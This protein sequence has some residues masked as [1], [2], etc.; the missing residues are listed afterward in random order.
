MRSVRIGWRA[1]AASALLAST[2]AADLPTALPHTLHVGSPQ[3][4]A[5]ARDVDA[6]RSRRAAE[7][8]APDRARV[9]WHRQLPGGISCNVLVDAEGRA[10][11]AG[12][13]RVSQL[14]RDGS[15]QFSLT[16]DFSAAAAA[17]L[18]ADG[19]RVLLTREGRLVGWSPAGT[20]AFDVALDAAAPAAS[21]SLLPL[22]DGGL[23][24][25]LG[26]WLFELDAT[27][28][29]RQFTSLP[30]ALQHTLRLEQHSVAVD[31]RG[32]VYTW[33]GREAPRRIGAFSGP[34]AA[35][36]ADGSALVGVAGR[37][38]ERLDARGD[39]RELARFDAGVAP[40]LALPA[41]GQPIAMQLDGVWSALPGGAPPSHLSRRPPPDALTRIDL[42]ADAAGTLAWWAAEVPLH[43]ETAPGSGREL[44]DVRCASPSSLVPAGAGQLIAACNSGAIWLI[45]PDAAT[46]PGPA[47]R[48]EDRPL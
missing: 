33:D 30:A 31:E 43:L 6:G 23:L 3:G 15:L 22:P 20:L 45:G 7:L 13:G 34:V 14:A 21:S 8:P 46:G 24:V 18:L 38:I 28:S 32:R 41:P 40:L 12:Q 16:S 10:F 1:L 4:F 35:V 19:T 36:V 25:S 44:N 26:P 9:A 37:N 11:V 2:V 5:T 17:A 42:L 39:V 29:R 47:V 27:R 48:P